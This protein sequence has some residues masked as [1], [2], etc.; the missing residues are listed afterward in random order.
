[1]MTI[2][3]L[4]AFA[5][6]ALLTAS[7]AAASD[8]SDQARSACMGDYSRFCFGTMPGGGRILACLGQ[9][10][11]DLAPDCAKAVGFGL[12]C[13]ADYQQLCP[14]VQPQN[15]GELRQCLERQQAKLSAGCARVLSSTR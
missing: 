6:A 3:T 10:L 5:F 15:G 13:V 12:E 2:R 1:M 8:I 14:G 4:S 9:H 11:P 7:G